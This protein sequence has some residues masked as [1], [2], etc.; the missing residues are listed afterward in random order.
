VALQV[1]LEE[2]HPAVMVKQ[3]LGQAE[4]VA[5]E[6]LPLGQSLGMAVAVLS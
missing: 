1:L 5:V 3:A 2:Q 4:V 6:V